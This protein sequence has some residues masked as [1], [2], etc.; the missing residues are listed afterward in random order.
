MRVTEYPKFILSE[1]MGKKTGYMGGR[2]GAQVADIIS[3]VRASIG[4]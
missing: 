3:A 1:L 4:R 2:G